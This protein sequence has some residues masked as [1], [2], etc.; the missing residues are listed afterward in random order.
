[1]KDEYEKLVQLITEAREFEASP[2]GFI[3]SHY[4]QSPSITTDFQIDLLNTENDPD[5]VKAA[6]AQVL[7]SI[8]ILNEANKIAQG[9]PE[10]MEQLDALSLE[11]FETNKRIIE[12]AKLTARYPDEPKYQQA[13]NKAQKDLINV[14]T[15]IA[16]LTA[17]TVVDENIHELEDTV[18]EV[19][20]QTPKLSQ[21]N[22]SSINNVLQLGEDLMTKM[23]NLIN[24]DFMTKSVEE[25]MNSTTQITNE[26]KDVAMALKEMAKQTTNPQVKQALINS[27]NVIQDNARKLKILAAVKAAQG[28]N[29]ED[30]NSLQSALLVLKSQMSSV[31]NEVTAL[32]LQHSVKNTEKQTRILKTIANQVRKVRTHR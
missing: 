18:N 11:L 16:G 17:P 19:P 14:V 27:S 12:T 13:L 15:K 5:I 24:M 1:M 10:L 23:D 9:N 4:I 28:N 3:D 31:M 21:Q 30:D 25:M 2:P 29:N 8:E 20:S 7:A 32:N 26:V 6:K 22:Q